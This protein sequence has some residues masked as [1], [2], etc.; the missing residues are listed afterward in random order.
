MTRL[1]QKTVAA[2]NKTFTETYAY[3]ANLSNSNYTTQLVRELNFNS[4]VGG[5]KTLSYTY[6]A[7]GNIKTVKEGSSEVA[8]YVV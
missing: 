5:V 7:N 8:S 4:G 2:K 3:L 6:D 1:T